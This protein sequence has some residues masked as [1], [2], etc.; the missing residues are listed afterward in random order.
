[1]TIQV[2]QLLQAAMEWAN[3]PEKGMM[4]RHYQVSD[5]TELDDELFLQGVVDE[6]GDLCEAITSAIGADE[7]V[8]NCATIQRLETLIPVVGAATR[9][10]YRFGL[11]IPVSGNARGKGAQ[12]S[13]VTSLYPEAGSTPKQG[14]NYFPFLRGDYSD[15]GQILTANYGTIVDALDTVL[16][17]PV[18]ATS[19]GA[20][21]PV[22]YSP[23][24]GL[25]KAVTSRVVRSVLG[26][27]RR[28]VDHHQPTK[29]VP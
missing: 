16:M 9:V 22:I 15:E 25:W 4:V 12:Q 8:F 6:L 13:V 21:I 11:G 23:T 7:T 29:V 1:M 19:I 10:L 20:I 2:G 24:T 28:R 14:R 17:D 5:A 27:Q 18:V 3:G 26:T